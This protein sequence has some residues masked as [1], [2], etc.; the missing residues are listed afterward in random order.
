[1]VEDWAQELANIFHEQ[2]KI[3]LENSNKIGTVVRGLSRSQLRCDFGPAKVGGG[4]NEQSYW[5]KGFTQ[6]QA[7]RNIRSRPCGAMDE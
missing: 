5:V 7:V 4:S 2:R 6:S 1:M 3:L